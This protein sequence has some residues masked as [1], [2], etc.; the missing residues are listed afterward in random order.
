[1]FDKEQ[2]AAFVSITAPDELKE[3]ILAME[4]GSKR[5]P[6]II[7]GICAAAC[8]LILAAIPLSGRLLQKNP[9]FYANG[10][11]IES[12]ALLL[13]ES[14]GASM[15]TF[16][17]SVPKYT[18]EISAE[19]PEKTVLTVSDGTMELV[20]LDSTEVIG[21]GTECTTEGGIIIRWIVDIPENTAEYYLTADTNGDKQRFVL[22]Y[23]FGKAAWY[24]MQKNNQ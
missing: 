1:M 20:S 6:H 22:Y 19:F 9:V 5:K 14:G 23:D 11:I 8:L 15:A 12:D 13:S 10:T 7:I 18:A 2:S 3:K 24:I 16:A 21:G 4:Q 17:R